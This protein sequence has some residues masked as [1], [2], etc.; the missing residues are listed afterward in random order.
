MNVVAIFYSNRAEKSILD[1]VAKVIEDHGL[2]LLYHD[3]SEAIKVQEDKDLS[4][5]Y[6]YIYN[7]VDEE[8]IGQVILCA[9]NP[10]IVFGAIQAREVTV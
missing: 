1:P 10:E 9:R 8:N 3:F 5:I 2:S 4:K 7:Y 6:N